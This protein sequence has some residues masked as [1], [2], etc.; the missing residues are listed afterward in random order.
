MP[1]LLFK[2]SALE[3]LDLSFNQLGNS[4]ATDL[5]RACKRA[6]KLKTLSLRDNVLND[7]SIDVD[8]QRS[9]VFLTEVHFFC[10][11][12]LRFVMMGFEIF[13]DKFFFQMGFCF[14]RIVFE[15]NL[16]K[17]RHT[18]SR[19]H[20]SSQFQHTHTHTHTYISDTVSTQI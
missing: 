2:D 14:L 12:D 1:T 3:E 5:L 20:T 8:Q 10:G 19:T 15:K 4:G 7:G 9:F 13:F 17:K 16:W 6:K 18:H 11:I